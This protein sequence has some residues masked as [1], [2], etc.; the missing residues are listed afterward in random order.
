MVT[1]TDLMLVLQC[2]LQ[3][4]LRSPTAVAGESPWI[5]LAT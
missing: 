2:L 3:L 5:E 1:T 4:C